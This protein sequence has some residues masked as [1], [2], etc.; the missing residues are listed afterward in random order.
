[1]VIVQLFSVFSHSPY[2]H[3]DIYRQAGIYVFTKSSKLYTPI[4]KRT[5]FRWRAFFFGLPLTPLRSLSTV[6]GSSS[7]R[8]ESVI[9]H[10]VYLD[11]CHAQV[12]IGK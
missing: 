7:H 1:M 10:L 4:V 5:G 8:Y 11:V 3:A 12:G 9:Y 6:Q 2:H